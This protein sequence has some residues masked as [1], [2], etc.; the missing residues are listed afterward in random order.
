M[1]RAD[2]KNSKISETLLICL[3]FSLA[4]SYFLYGYRYLDIGTYFYDE[5]I[6]AY[7][8]TRILDGAVPYRDFW[9]LYNPGEF[10]MLAFIFKLFGISIKVAWLFAITVLS[11]TV[12]SIYL[13]IKRLCSRILGILGLLLSLAWLKSYMVFNRPG[14]LAILFF[15]LCSL[16]L[17]NFIDSGRKRWLIITGI[18]SGIIGLFRQDFGFYVFTSIFLV[19]MLRQLNRLKGNELS[20]K[21][22]SILKN[23][24]FLFIGFFIIYLPLLIY[25]IANSAFKGFINDTI[26][27][28][29]TTYPKARDLPFPGLKL[30]TLIFYL[31][32]FVFLLTCVRL[33]FFKWKDKIEDA[34]PWILL[35][36]LFSGL[37]LFNYTSLRTC[38]PQLLPTMIPVIILF[39]LLFNG[40]LKRVTGK[41]TPFYKNLIFATSSLVCFILL[42]YLTKPSFKLFAKKSG[43]AT[44]IQI[45]NS[46]L[47]IDRGRGFYGDS[48]RVESLTAA[49]RYIQDNTKNDEKI[50]VGNLMH[51]KTVNSDVMFY[52]LSER[53][54]ATKYYELHPG[55]TNTR[56]IQKEI[57]GDLIKADVR[58]IILSSEASHINDIDDSNESGK[59]SGVK[60]L[61]NFIQNKYKV[62]KTFG[63]YLILKR[64]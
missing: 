15:I 10:Y 5:G 55:L 23:E 1:M 2:L 14:Q 45:K 25:L 38:M 3:L 6:V 18:L 56:R 17:I 28:T 9:T 37:G 26:V 16:S 57:I 19:V 22:S 36:F 64:V 44:G 51:D 13:L 54:S 35:F 61:D 52:F 46:S 42:F 43:C 8:A 12:C 47:N 27:F 59:S 48:Q 58:Y 63:A 60:D 62:E 20:A 33:L 24:L 34:S 4:F 7:G 21:L 32:L 40:F 53:N 31:P 50:F 11:L 30:D 49:I 41:N 39:V 29:V